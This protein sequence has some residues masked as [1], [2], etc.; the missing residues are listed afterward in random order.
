MGILAQL[1]ADASRWD[2][3]H[4]KAM[5]VGGS[6]VP[7]A[8]IAA[9]QQR[10]GIQIVQ[11]WGMTET[12]P[13]ASTAALPH[14]LAD[15]DEETRFDL[16]AMAGIPLPF[17]EVRARVG[18]EEIPWDGEAMGELEVR[19]P[20]VASSY[21]D[22]PESADRWT[23]DG[24]FK[25]GDI[26]SLH[27]RGYIQIKDR[28]K[29]VIKSGGEWISSVEL[30]NALMAHPAVAEAAVIAVPDEKWAER[31]LACVVVRDGAAVTADEL[32]EFL[33]PQFAKWWLPDRI[34]FIAE[35]PKT[36][37]GKFRKIA[38]REQF[39]AEQQPV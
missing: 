25:T 8:M 21:Y 37:V 16:E 27:P 32:K 5:L 39:A 4:M 7:R 1:D 18:D 31:P 19:G 28:S 38:L 13:V 34:E 22:A 17:V 6:A 36:S 20:W 35:I 11:G 10:H 15:V 29:D 24:W 14:D 26:V 33:A 12:S 9:Y 23:A 3:S 2:L 30:E